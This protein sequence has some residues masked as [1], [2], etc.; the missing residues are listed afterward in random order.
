MYSSESMPCSIGDCDSA[1][2][3]TIA[4]L[5]R[6]RIHALFVYSDG[7]ATAKVNIFTTAR[8]EIEMLAA[9]ADLNMSYV[10]D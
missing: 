1:F 4:V 8:N 9:V 3:N 10:K 5:I 6:V 7:K 2:S